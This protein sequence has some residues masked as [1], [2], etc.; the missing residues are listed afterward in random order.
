MAN[1]YQHFGAEESAFIDQASSWIKQVEDRNVAHATYFLNPREFWILE[2]LVN[3]ADLQLFSSASWL[4]GNEESLSAEVEYVKAIIAPLSA[5]RPEWADF[6]IAL[7]QIDYASKFKAIT[8][9]QILGTFLG[10]TG[11]DRREI[12]DIFVTDD[13]AQIF[14]T[15]RLVPVFLSDVT[16]I[17]GLNV[18]LIEVPISALIESSTTKTN[19]VLLVSSLRLDKILSAALRIPRNLA[20]NMIQSKKVKVNYQAISRNDLQLSIQDLISIR[21]F[22]RI[23]LMADLGKTKKDKE[24]IEIEQISNHKK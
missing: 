2:T 5:D 4:T 14:V 20:V 17:S 18:R 11:L 9:S 12:G 15:A 13:K 22:G 24:K 21:G 16:K 23:R 8:H 7:L 3:R 10:E 1:L 6:D 19:S